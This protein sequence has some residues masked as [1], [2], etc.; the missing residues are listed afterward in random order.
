VG[1]TD[2]DG[3][4]VTH[5]EVLADDET[6]GGNWYLAGYTNTRLIQL[7]PAKPLDA[8]PR[9]F[10]GCGHEIVYT[11]DG[12]QHDSAEWFW[13]GDHDAGPDAK[14]I[15]AAKAY[16]LAFPEEEDVEEVN[17]DDEDA[18][19]DGDGCAIYF[20]NHQVNRNGDMSKTVDVS[21]LEAGDTYHDPDSD[22]DGKW[23]SVDEVAKVGE[24]NIHVDFSDEDS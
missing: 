11:G 14:A 10:C 20:A 6:R 17:E 4:K 23:W 5:I 9:S 8:R 13:G 3:R 2:S 15:A 12:W 19:E 7:D 24:D 1:L 22:E 18:H 16:D 21:D